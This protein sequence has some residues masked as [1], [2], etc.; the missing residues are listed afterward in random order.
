MK[1][2]EKEEGME[3]GSFRQWREMYRRGLASLYEEAEAD[4]LY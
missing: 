1:T 3:K 2:D 4:S